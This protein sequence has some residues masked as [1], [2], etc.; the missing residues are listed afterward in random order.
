MSTIESAGQI[1]PANQFPGALAPAGAPAAG[2]E[3]GS[4]FTARDAWRVVKQRKLLIIVVA[5]VLYLL[6]IAATFLI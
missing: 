6:F 1:V 3:A 2:A 5:V 4:A